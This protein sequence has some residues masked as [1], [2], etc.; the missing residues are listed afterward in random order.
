MLQLPL[1]VLNPE[2]PYLFSYGCLIMWLV[3]FSWNPPPPPPVVLAPSSAS[4]LLPFS[5]PRITSYVYCSARHPLCHS[6]PLMLALRPGC[7]ISFR[8]PPY[9]PLLLSSYWL[10]PDSSIPWR[11][12]CLPRPL[13]ESTP[14]DPPALIHRPVLPFPGSSPQCYPRVKTCQ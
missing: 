4:V 13:P 8:P 6:R 7:P 5:P 10:R 9:L 14:S 11:P 12:L 1:A 3:A 2:P